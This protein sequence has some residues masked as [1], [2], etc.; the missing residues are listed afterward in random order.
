MGLVQRLRRSA[1]GTS[2]SP[3]SNIS[4]LFRIERSIA[5]SSRK[6]KESDK[7]RAVVDKFF[8]WCD[9]ER[10][11]ACARRDAHSGSS[12]LRNQPASRPSGVSSMTGG[13]PR[14]KLLPLLSRV[15]FAGEGNASATHR[16]GHARAAQL[17]PST[18]I[19]SSHPSTGRP[20]KRNVASQRQE[21]VI[22]ARRPPAP[23]FARLYCVT[24]TRDQ[25]P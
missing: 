5:D 3:S 20:R 4:A 22:N 2:R 23:L 6:E 25:Y 15:P 7:S 21:P 13:S 10:A 1:P 14:T 24:F 19:L 18:A 11:A 8:E 16:R 9:G 17:A 12:S